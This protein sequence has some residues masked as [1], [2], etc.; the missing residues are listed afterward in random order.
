MRVLITGAS[1]SGTSTLARALAA[2]LG[3]R[4]FDLD[5]YFW[6]PTSPPFKVKRDAE[7]RLSMLVRDLEQ[8]KIALISGSIVTWGRELADSMSIIVFLTVPTEI[9]VER[10]RRREQEQLGYIDPAFIEWAAQYDEGRLPGRNRQKHE[11]WLAERNVPI[12]RIDGEVSL[13]HSR[14][15][16]LAAMKQLA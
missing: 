12:V 6:V 16:V 10:L 14:S 1:G 7:E 15:V 3:T 13:E 2:E 11:Q 8:V 4:A 9:R 5:D